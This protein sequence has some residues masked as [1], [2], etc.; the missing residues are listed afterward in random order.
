[1]INR[2]LLGELQINPDIAVYSYIK[3]RFGGYGFNKAQRD[4]LL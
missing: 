1:M 2:W 4:E 3:V